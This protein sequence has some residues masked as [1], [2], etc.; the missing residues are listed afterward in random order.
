MKMTK[1][2]VEGTCKGGLNCAMC[3]RRTVSGEE[4]RLAF[5]GEK[6]FVCPFGVPWDVDANGI[7]KWLRGKRIG[8]KIALTLLRFH[9]E[10]CPGCYGRVKMFD[11]DFGPVDLTIRPDIPTLDE[12]WQDE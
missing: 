6:D 2:Q 1:E 3:R 10:T 5:T 4:F 8:T 11:G 12:E 9:R 7:V